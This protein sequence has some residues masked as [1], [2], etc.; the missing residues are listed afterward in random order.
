[1]QTTREGE[2]VA[3]EELRE[4]GSAKRRK[5]NTCGSG[6]N[7]PASWRTRRRYTVAFTKATAGCGQCY[8]I[9]P[10]TLSLHRW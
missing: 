2:E 6:A 1:M 10:E 8:A 5:A 7:H 3:I 9:R 4:Y